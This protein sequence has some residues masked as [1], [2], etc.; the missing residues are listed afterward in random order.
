[1]P[2][3]HE[4]YYDPVRGSSLVLTIDETVQSIVEKYMKQD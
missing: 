1:M 4:T 3:H 2:Y